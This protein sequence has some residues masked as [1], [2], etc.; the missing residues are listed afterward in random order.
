MTTATSKLM[1]P[2]RVSARDRE[3]YEQV[4]IQGKPQRTVGIE[5]GLSQPRVAAILKRVRKWMQTPQP[6]LKDEGDREA[7]LREQS[8]AYRLRLMHYVME[9]LRGWMESRKAVHTVK[10]IK[11]SEGKIIREEH[12]AKTSPGNCKFL[13]TA[14]RFSLALLKF[15]GMD[16][17][18]EVDLSTENRLVEPPAL[19]KD[20]FV[21][22]FKKFAQQVEEMVRRDKEA[23][24]EGD[25]GREGEEANDL[26]SAAKPLSKVLS[27]ENRAISAEKRGDQAVIEPVIETLSGVIDP[28]SDVIKPLSDSLS[29]TLSEP[30]SEESAKSEGSEEKD[31]LKPELQQEPKFGYYPPPAP[32]EPQLTVEEARAKY[33]WLR[34]TM[35]VVTEAEK[36]TFWVK[37]TPP[38]EYPP[39][40]VSYDTRTGKRI[41][42]DPRQRDPVTGELFDP[43]MPW[44]RP[45]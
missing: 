22:E 11:D 30:L 4:E 14:M 10:T 12:T 41:E 20:E 2:M 3:I 19:T 24:G 40:N 33:A 29:E 15:D 31:R 32:P 35:R 16:A 1:R 9:A 27:G 6:P 37:V 45:W 44:P 21:V 23:A 28:L 42:K 18:G 43:G 38:R 25:S 17:S 8:R 39:S 34:P 7:R 5:L 13:E 26:A 36:K